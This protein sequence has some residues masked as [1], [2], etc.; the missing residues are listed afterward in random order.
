MRASG[1]AT[2]VWVVSGQ[3]QGQTAHC[4]YYLR[5]PLWIMDALKQSCVIVVF[6][7][8]T[9]VGEPPFYARAEGL[10]DL[11]PLTRR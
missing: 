10:V 1:T 4:S 5:L 6:G 7:L 3:V 2:S 8:L 11:P 9:R